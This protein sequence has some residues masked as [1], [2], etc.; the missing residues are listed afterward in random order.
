MRALRL[1]VSLALLAQAAG[2]V[3]TASFLNVGV[4]ARGLG[5]GG[6]YTALADDAD[7]IYWNPAGLAQVEKHEFQASDSELAQ[8]TREGFFSYAQTVPLG[9]FAAGATYLNEGSIDG[10]D[11]QG[12]ATAG[13][14]AA[15]ASVAGAFACK[16]DLVDLGGSVKFIQSHIGSAQATTFGMDLGARRR[17]GPVV[18]GA[19]LRNLGPGMKFDSETDDL[20][21]RLA[22]GAAYKFAGGHALTAEFTN[23]PRAGGSDAGFGG[24]YQALKGIFLRA[25]YTTQSAI[26]GGTGFDAVRGLTLGV[27]YHSA[28]WTLDY[29]AVPMGELGSTHRFTL[30]TKW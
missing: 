20:P 3:E 26:A 30:G 25:G 5:M 14:S 2:A 18:L 17:I 24:E 1:A 12:H 28:H 6:A 10:R 4:G 7:A 15:D 16:T 8:N 21:M 11:A 22:L 9:T 27:G 13:F 19:S 29:A 23:A